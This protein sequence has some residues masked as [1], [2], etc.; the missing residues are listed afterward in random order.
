M[1]FDG[2]YPTNSSQI[3]LFSLIH[4]RFC[5]LLFILNLQD[6]FVPQIFFLHV[7]SSTREWSTHSSLQLP[8]VP[9]LVMGFHVQLHLP[10]WDLVYLG[11]AQGSYVLSHLCV[12]ASYIQKS[13]FHCSHLRPQAL[14]LF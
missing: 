14:R 2:I 9:W 12:A 5:T 10:S 7:L 3:H 11:I 13:L 8:V 6:K 4:L 1:C